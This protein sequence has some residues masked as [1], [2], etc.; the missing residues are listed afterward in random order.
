MDILKITPE[1]AVAIQALKE[2]DIL[3]VIAT[4]RTEMEIKTNHA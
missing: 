2:N 4:G 3:P 1:I